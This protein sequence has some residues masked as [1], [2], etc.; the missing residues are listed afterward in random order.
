MRY[1]MGMSLLALLA[2]AAAAWLWLRGADF[3]LTGSWDRPLHPRYE[4][5][6]SAGS[7]GLALG[8][9]GTVLIVIN[10]TFMLRKNIRALRRFGALRAW[11]D[12]HVV[13]G[14]LGPLLILYHTA[15]A[16]KTRV[17][18]TA[19]VC[20]LILVITGIVGR[21]IYAMV[22][23]TVSG[24]ELGRPDLERRLSEARTRLSAHLDESHPAWQTLERLGSRP[25][26]VPR[27]R[28]V[29]LLVLPLLAFD[30]ALLRARA[31]RLATRLRPEVPD[32]QLL[33][34]VRDTTIIRRR[35]H[36]LEVLRSLM[37]W[38]RSMH[39]ALAVVMIAA[40]LVH[41]GVVSYFGY[42]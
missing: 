30:A 17:A 42:A 6:R 34:T 37:R 40:V 32:P 29:C 35:L 2:I 15:F 24:A 11:M 14:L 21:F 25:L 22:P 19:T 38:W 8:I 28:I 9:A 3:Y 36:V 12:V 4:T 41:I 39:R 5:L 33:D 20:L 26:V 1:R 18:I 31:H 16:F 13:T 23:H 10:L 27:T 7:V